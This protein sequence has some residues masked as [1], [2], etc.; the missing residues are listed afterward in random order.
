MPT[1]KKISQR[2]ARDWKRR[3]LAAELLLAPEAV[4]PGTRWEVCAVTLTA[5]QMR[6]VSIGARFGYPH[7]WERFGNV[8]RLYVYQPESPDA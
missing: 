6:E 4:T 2:E 7:R 1:R 3:A 5:A 8:Y